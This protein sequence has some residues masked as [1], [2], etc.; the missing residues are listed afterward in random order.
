[1]SDS[2]E[3]L[4]II[5][6]ERLTLKQHFM[7]KK[8]IIIAAA[9]AMLAFVACKKDPVDV[10]VVDEPRNPLVGKTWAYYSDTNIMGI[11][12]VQELRL[13]FYTDSI[14][15][16]YIG[17]EDS[18]SPWWD[19][20]YSFRYIFHPE[21]NGMELYEDVSPYPSYFRYYPENQTLTQGEIIFHLVEQ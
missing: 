11:R 20:T 6:A 1:L 10:P 8:T 4:G 21:L 18:Y 7:K 15:E 13:A 12:V 17:S 16:S 19:T 3:K 2:S 9:T 14:G 5:F